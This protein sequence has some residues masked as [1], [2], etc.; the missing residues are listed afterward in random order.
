MLRV[1][2]LIFNFV[3]KTHVMLGCNKREAEPGGFAPTKRKTVNHREEDLEVR[4]VA[5]VWLWE[6]EMSHGKRRDGVKRREVK[7]RESC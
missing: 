5:A 7:P 6:R 3:K 4:D 2:T 1:S